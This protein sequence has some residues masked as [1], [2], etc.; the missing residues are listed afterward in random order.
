VRP[1]QIA[2]AD[3]DGLSSVQQRGGMEVVENTGRSTARQS[4]S[5][6]AK[7]FASFMFARCAAPPVSRMR[8]KSDATIVYDGKART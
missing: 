6:S 3:F 2:E 5:F 8:F 7:K 1:L 4:K